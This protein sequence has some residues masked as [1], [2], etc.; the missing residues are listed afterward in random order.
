MRR[1]FPARY[2]LSFAR[3]STRRAPDRSILSPLHALL[4]WFWLSD[5][6]L[7]RK[8]RPVPEV[9]LKTG[10][11]KYPQKPVEPCQKNHRR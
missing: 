1:L 6:G 11:D 8:D 10:A 4:R 3:W 2:R 7:V 9:K 5:C